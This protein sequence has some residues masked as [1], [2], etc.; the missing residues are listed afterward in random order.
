MKV[1]FGVAL[2]VVFLAATAHAFPAQGQLYGDNVGK[3]VDTLLVLPEGSLG[4]GLE[5]DSE[6]FPYFFNSFRPPSF[7]DFFSGMQEALLRLRAQ[8]A[9]MLSKVPHGGFIG[10]PGELPE[11][12]NTTSTTKI[13]DGHVVTIN[14]TTYS[15]GDD[16]NGSVIRVRVIDIK[17]QQNGTVRPD[18]DSD[19]EAVP[20]TDSPKTTTV[21][22]DKSPETLEDDSDN[23]IPNPD[24]ITA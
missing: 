23:A 12:A 8:M 1:V 16:L 15:T 22:S 18:T 10:T 11:G 19:V 6:E 13:I 5:D 21:S 24:E 20:G 4:S 17:P 14:Q 2:A 9:D 3:N 7:L